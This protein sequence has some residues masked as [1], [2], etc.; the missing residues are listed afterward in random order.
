MSVCVDCYSFNNNHTH[1]SRVHLPIDSQVDRTHPSRLYVVVGISL[2]LLDSKKSLLYNFIVHKKYI[3]LGGCDIIMLW[4]PLYYY[5][6][7]NNIYIGGSSCTFELVVTY[8]KLGWRNIIIITGLNQS[9]I[10]ISYYG[11][12]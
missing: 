10:F 11:N 5:R 2:Y 6:S 4:M 3:I 12:C 8:L 7:I 9:V 1:T